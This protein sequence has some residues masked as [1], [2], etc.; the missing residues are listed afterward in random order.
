[1]RPPSYYTSLANRHSY[2]PSHTYTQTHSNYGDSGSGS[3]LSSSSYTS[4]LSSSALR[5]SLSSPSS[6]AYAKRT[7]LPY[8]AQS[9]LVAHAFTGPRSYGGSTSSSYSS[10]YST[11]SSS[12]YAPSSSSTAST[13]SSRPSSLKRSAQPSY[14]SS[15]SAFRSKNPYL[16]SGASLPRTSYLS[17]TS[18]RSTYTPSRPSITHY[19]QPVKLRERPLLTQISREIN[20]TPSPGLTLRHREASAER[21]S[22]AEDEPSKREQSPARERTQGA[23][24]EQSAGASLKPP[25]PFGTSERQDPEKDWS[26]DVTRLISRNKF[27]IKFRE[28]DKQH[29]PSLVEHN[30]NILP[31][32]ETPEPTTQKEEADAASVEQISDRLSST[33]IDT[34]DRVDDRKQVPKIAL[35]QA[36]EATPDRRPEADKDAV[37]VEKAVGEKPPPAAAK[38]K[39]ENAKPKAVKVVKVKR[40]KEAEAKAIS[41]TESIDLKPAKTIDRSERAV[42][43]VVES[44][45]CQ[46]VAVKDK[47][48]PMQVSASTEQARRLAEQEETIR[49]AL[50]H[51]RASAD[52]KLKLK[53]AEVAAPSPSASAPA[54][55]P[56]SASPST[57]PAT[58]DSPKQKAKRTD[59]VTKKSKGSTDKLFSLVPVVKTADE[60]VASDKKAEAE[61]PRSPPTN[62]RIGDEKVRREPQNETSAAEQPQTPV[63][64]KDK[65]QAKEKEN[66]R[67]AT[68]N[69]KVAPEE[70]TKKEIKKKKLKVKVSLDGTGKQKPKTKAQKG[71]ESPPTPASANEVQ[72]RPAD[73]SL[74]KSNSSESVA[75]RA[76]QVNKRIKFREYNLDDF[77]FL[78]VLGHGG[79]GFV[80]LAELKEHDACFAV[81]C[82]K[83]ITIVEDDDFDSIMI[84][85]KMLTL[86]NVNPFICKLFCTFETEV[87]VTRVE[88][89]STR[90]NQAD[91]FRSDRAIC[92]LLWST[93]PAAI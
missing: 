44:E 5:S 55:T 86:G 83:K 46:V 45:R 49:I 28:F 48:Q 59:V 39:R 22:P 7:H 17:S 20:R 9:T 90:A 81:K 15:S 73:A 88:P 13:Y 76:R 91:R 11:P 33:R 92:F 14:S 31:V 77:N 79:W 50:K 66:E 34:P 47:I 25:S 89:R 53:T 68:A 87:S 51:R 80:I 4:T 6:S 61:A 35:E 65:A 85:R 84:E 64:P 26:S 10:S 2:T 21:K 82:I 32:P 29:R 71:K 78:S 23:A 74:D 41:S 70:P 57:S 19:Y 1:M 38:E 42:E 52:K 36:V 60:P 56:D 24:G 27:I 75:S 67:P 16:S 3:G 58:A 63:G 72:E 43:R 30:S 54:E 37:E 40:A 93:V 12:Y 18:A 8:V 62:Q 69:E